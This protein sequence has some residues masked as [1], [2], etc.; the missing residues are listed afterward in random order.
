[1]TTDN[2]NDHNLNAPVRKNGVPTERA[3]GQPV[4]PSA[5]RSPHHT[6]NRQVVHLDSHTVRVPE[7]PSARGNANR[8][9]V[10]TGKQPALKT[11]RQQAVGGKRPSQTGKQQAVGG[12]RPSQTGKQ[13]A[14]GGKRPSQTGRQQA[15]TSKPRESVAKHQQSSATAARALKTTGIAIAAL[16]ALYLIGA[17]VFSFIFVPNTKM[18][19]FDLSLKTKA[20]AETMIND[21]LKDYKI[22]VSG[23][24]FSFVATADQTGLA[25]DAKS[26]VEE[27]HADVN[28]WAWPVLLL[29]GSH[30][31]TDKLAAMGDT[32]SIS[33]LTQTA[34]DEFNTEAT[35][36]VQANIAYDASRSSFVVVSEKEG[37]QLDR[38]KVIES[39]GYAVANFEPTLELTSE[40]ILKPDVYSSDERL[41]D[42]ITKA[43][44]MVNSNVVLKLGGTTVATIDSSVLS[45][46]ISID[47][48]VTPVLSASAYNDWEY[49]FIPK[50]NTVGDARTFTR[51]DGMSVTVSGGVFGWKVDETALREQLEHA[52][53]ACQ[54][55]DL[56]V[57]CTQKGDVYTGP[58]ERDWKTRYI[59]VDI[60]EQHVR[61]YG[62]DG[63]IIWEADCITGTPDGERDTVPGVWAVNDK[64]SP[65]K[66][67][68]KKNGV[69]VYETDVTYWMPFESDS[70]GFHDATWQTRFG[71]AY[72]EWGAGSH[73]CV[74]LSLDD[75]ALLY[76]IIQVGDVVVVHA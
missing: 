46:M 54:R 75:A 55:G 7:I 44:A 15:V 69:V 58:G 3:S 68:G 32:G 25:V 18:G 67:I 20:G 6:D 28:G 76:G 53:Q 13:Q 19:S 59:D 29:S 71:S 63:S 42:A 43:N 56:E 52:V 73:G 37:T 51:A 30:D 38:Q 36:P 40:H 34:V 60:S 48:T 64:K 27:A 35:A 49:G 50:V 8:P 5:P 23:N 66:L 61:F 14:V 24:G 2:R 45:T 57:P 62:D 47:S 74:N 9:S 41:G 72:Y 10:K 11:G 21:V 16:V 12:I 26:A 17:L 22:T 65:N 39:V 1:M 4:K 70:I 31:E 33:Q